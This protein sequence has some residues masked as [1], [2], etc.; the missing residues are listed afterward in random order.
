MCSETEICSAFEPSALLQEEAFIVAY[1]PPFL[2][3]MCQSQWAGLFFC[4]V[5]SCY[6]QPC[7]K[8]TAYSGVLQEQEW[9]AGK[10][11]HLR[12]LCFSG[13]ALLHVLVFV[14]WGG[15]SLTWIRGPS[16][17]LLVAGMMLL[18]SCHCFPHPP[19][20]AWRALPD[21]EYHKILQAKFVC[22]ITGLEWSWRKTKKR[23]NGSERG[24]ANERLFIMGL[25]LERHLWGFSEA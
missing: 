4:P 5:V 15:R 18:A 2:L 1:T 21:G 11:E 25:F 8:A 19:N 7:R 20:T 14:A 3:W 9:V 24:R 13:T 17:M 23:K 22:S 12:L 6:K 16:V 10:G